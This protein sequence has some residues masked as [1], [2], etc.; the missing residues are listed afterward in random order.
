[1]SAWYFRS[2][3]Q[4]RLRM[5]FNS[6]CF[7]FIFP[8]VLF[9]YYLIPERYKKIWILFAGAVFFCFVNVR[10]LFAVYAFALLSWFGGIVLCKRKKKSV[11]FLCL[12]VCLLPLFVF[13]VMN[14][15][16][17]A[18]IPLGLSF[19]SLQAVCYL[20]EL[21][22]G[23]KE[24]TA[25]LSDYML[26]MT[27]FP[28]ISSGP[29]KRPGEF[30]PQINREHPFHYESVRSGLYQMALGYLEKIVLADQLGG[31]VDQVFGN[32]ERIP[33][34]CIAIGMAAFGIQ[35]Y[36][37]FAG[38][39]HLAI[40]SAQVLGYQIPSNFRQPY[41]AVSIKDFWRR[42]HI[43]LSSWLRDYVYFPL[44]GSRVSGF[45][46]N[47]NVM[48]TFL[49]S[50]LWHGAGFHYLIWGGLHGVYQIAGS[51]TEKVRGRIRK[52]LHLKETNL[53]YRIFRSI[54]VF[55]LVDYAWLFFR[56]ES[57]HA[58]ILMTGKMLFKFQPVEGLAE[59]FF[60]NGMNKIQICLWLLSA[61]FVFCLDLCRERN[62]DY[63]QKLAHWPLAVRWFIYLA[64][65]GVLMV[66]V[67][68]GIG[69]DASAFIYN[70]F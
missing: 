28:C 55:I 17:S 25:G 65:T 38:Y 2:G 66:G 52:T 31:L 20:V 39:S 60:I 13:K 56:A 21:Y 51:G 6:I 8:A 53:I 49:V 64:V 24:R 44:G 4:R 18:V 12:G 30:M 35:L 67:L 29:V 62:I 9:F 14:W 59:W 50:G 45:R 22:R 16:Y 43:S 33:G 46:R 41:F 58:G 57:V 3:S 32:Y 42:W 11:L 47:I 34:S 7:V 69:N 19:Y 10:F 37:D 48:V 23:E 63:E 27:F 40:G 68:A 70:N 36:F 54:V 15:K 5:N 26:F 61:A 1:M